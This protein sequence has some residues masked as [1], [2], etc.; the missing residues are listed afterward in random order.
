[1]CDWSGKGLTQSTLA[2]HERR[3]I[4]EGA[5]SSVFGRS[6]SMESIP[7]PVIPDPMPMLSTP[8]FFNSVYEA[9]SNKGAMARG[10]VQSRCH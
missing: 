7:T 1:M 2:G 3:Q 4:R 8:A 6:G 10:V 9:T 5:V